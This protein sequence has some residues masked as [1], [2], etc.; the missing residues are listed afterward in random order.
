MSPPGTWPSLIG[1]QA[2]ITQPGCFF[3]PVRTTYVADALD[4]RRRELLVAVML[5]L[6]VL[7]IG[8]YAQLVLDFTRTACEGWV[9]RLAVA[10]P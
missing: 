8:F 9:S 3:G 6:L 5:A 10:A 4:L 1:V 7:I 2:P